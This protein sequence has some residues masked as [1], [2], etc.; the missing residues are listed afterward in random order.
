MLILFQYEQCGHSRAVREK[1][2]ELSLD[3][4]LIN[5]EHEDD[6]KWDYLEKHSGG[7]REV[8]F[9]M[10]TTYLKDIH[11]VKDII[12]HLELYYSHNSRTKP[13]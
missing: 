12:K 10:D 3:V 5:I 4:V 7:I 2:T 1:L 13:F 6:P 8:P 9:L 11:G